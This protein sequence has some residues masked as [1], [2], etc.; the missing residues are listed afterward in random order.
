MGLGKGSAPFF[1]LFFTIQEEKTFSLEGT[2][3][4][5]HASSF[6]THLIHF[7][8]TSCNFSL[9][10]HAPKL[11]LAPDFFVQSE[12]GDALDFLRKSWNVK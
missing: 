7:F 4:S 11:L 2:Q 12:P 3:A 10:A 9:F 6:L 1:L 5:S 8:L